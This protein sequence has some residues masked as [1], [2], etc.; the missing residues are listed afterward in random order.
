MKLPNQNGKWEIEAANRI[1]PKQI[2]KKEDQ[3]RSAMH[4]AR[5]SNSKISAPIFSHFCGCPPK[6]ST[7]NEPYN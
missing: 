6:C 1:K 3:P 7:T 4:I 2:K 5:S